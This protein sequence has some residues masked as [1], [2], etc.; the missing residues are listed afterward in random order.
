MQLLRPADP[1]HHDSMIQWQTDL[2]FLTDGEL[3]AEYLD[4]DVVPGGPQCDALAAE[5][6][7]WNADL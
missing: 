2:Q 4:G 6:E 7:R 1:Q 5:L 3:R